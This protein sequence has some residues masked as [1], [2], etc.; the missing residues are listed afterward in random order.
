MDANYL[1]FVFGG[2]SANAFGIWNLFLL[3]LARVL[4][5]VAITPF[6]GSKSIPNPAKMAIALCVAT[7]MLPHLATTSKLFPV[8]NWTY[9]GLFIK[10]IFIG[11][12]IA[13]IATIPFWVAQSSGIVIDFM[14]G[15]SSMI[16][17]DPTMRNQ[18]SSLG[19][20]YNQMTI[21]L[22]YS[23]GGATIF[24]STLM[25]SY[26]ILPPDT[27]IHPIFFAKNFPFWK[28]VITLASHIM[29]MALQLAAPAIVGGLMAEVFLGIA[30]RMAPQVQIAFLGISIRSMLAIG[31]LCAGWIVVLN[32]ISAET[33]NWL[34]MLRKSTYM[35][36]VNG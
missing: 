20:L 22:F 7:V 5:V 30:N 17:Q 21:V 14:R 28:Q 8:M 16:G 15:A 13:Y 3:S 27:W 9:A 6:F 36:R 23:I 31:L 32:Q 34:E 26:I 33:L 2:D 1:D 10:E 35:L 19:I 25:N 18:V 24:L 29:A 12:I 4:P 11:T